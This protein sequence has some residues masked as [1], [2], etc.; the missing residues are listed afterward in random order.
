[1]ASIHIIQARLKEV[2]DEIDKI[3]CLLLEAKEELERAEICKVIKYPRMSLK[4]G[5]MNIAMGHDHCEIYES[6]FVDGVK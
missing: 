4:P 6:P 1:M 2:I 5:G 3:K